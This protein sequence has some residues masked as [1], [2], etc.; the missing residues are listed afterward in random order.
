VDRKVGGASYLRGHE[1][2]GGICKRTGKWEG[3]HC[4]WTEKLGTSFTIGQESG[5]DKM[6][7]LT[8]KNK[9]SNLTSN[10]SFNRLLNFYC[11][12]FHAKDSTFS[13]YIAPLPLFILFVISKEICNFN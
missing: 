3:E 1:S 12:G 2:V 5:R 7:K 4:K 9:R 6:S 10:K 13:R 8:N 11:I